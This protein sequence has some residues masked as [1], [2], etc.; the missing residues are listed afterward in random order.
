MRVLLDTHALLWWWAGNP[1]FSHAARDLLSDPEVEVY[2]S[3]ATAWEIA[4][5]VRIGK[6]PEARKLIG[7]F[8]EAIAEHDFLHLPVSLK[9]GLHAGLLQGNHRDPFDRIIATQALID[10]LQVVTAD[11]AIKTLGARTMW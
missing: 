8:E 2:V 9:H 11:A 4:T 3:A 10:D 7:H 6:L 5:K 1:R